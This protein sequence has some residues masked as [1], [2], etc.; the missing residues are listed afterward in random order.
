MNDTRSR[1]HYF[2]KN[3]HRK[4][5]GFRTEH[6]IDN[7]VKKDIITIRFFGMKKHVPNVQ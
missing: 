4:T 6:L 5:E 7:M 1:K 2:W 3:N